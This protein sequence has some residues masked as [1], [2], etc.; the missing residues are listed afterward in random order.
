MKTI[1]VITRFALRGESNDV[2]DDKGYQP[3]TVRWNGSYFLVTHVEDYGNFASGFVKCS[4]TE[5][6]MV[7][8]AP[9][10]SE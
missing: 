10:T 4:C 1:V 6:N 8:Q 3:D 2:T 5:T 9:R 7:G